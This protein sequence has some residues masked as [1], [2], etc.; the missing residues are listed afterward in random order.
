MKLPKIDLTSLPDMELLTGLFGT[1]QRPGHDDSII[2]IATVVYD[3]CPPGC[4]GIV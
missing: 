3:S 4:G 1:T 2:V